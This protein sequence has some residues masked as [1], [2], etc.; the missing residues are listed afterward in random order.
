MLRERKVRWRTLNSIHAKR[1]GTR[2]DEQV[3]SGE[4]KLCDERPGTTQQDGK[5]RNPSF[6]GS[7]RSSLR[8]P[9]MNER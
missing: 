2:T 3:A 5:R 9:R 8:T 1:N 6:L 7:S 4:S